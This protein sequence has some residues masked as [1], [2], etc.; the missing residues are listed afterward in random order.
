MLDG[1]KEWQDC[2]IES[3]GRQ[4]EF[5]HVVNLG[6]ES[7]EWAHNLT[8]KQARK[9]LGQECDL[10]IADVTQGFDANGFAAALGT[11]KGGG[12]LLI[13]DSGISDAFGTWFEKSLN[14]LHRLSE[15][16]FHPSEYMGEAQDITP[17]AEQTLAIEAVRKVLTGH[18]KRPLVVTADRGRGK[19]SALGIASAQ[20]LATEPK[21]ILVTAPNKTAV[22]TL[23]QRAAIELDIQAQGMKLQSDNGGCLEYIAPDALLRD[24]PDCDLLL[25]DEA[26]AIPLPMLHKIVERYHR[27]CLATT[28]HGYEGC[29]RGFSVKFEPWLDKHKKGW[30]ALR[31]TQPIRWNPTD[32][33]E[34]WLFDALLLDA[35]V[36]PINGVQANSVAYRRVSRDELIRDRSLLQQCFALLVNAHYQ[37][38]P[39]DLVQLLNDPKQVM[40]VAHANNQILAVVLA[41][42]EGGLDEGII[43]LVMQGKRRPAGHLVA[44]SLS[45]HLSIAEPSRLDS[46][47]VMRIA[48]HPQLQRQGI[49]SSTL[50]FVIQQTAQSYAFLSTSFG[51]TSELYRFW[52]KNSFRCLRLGSKQD[53]ASGCFSSILVRPLAAQM[54]WIEDARQLFSLQLVDTLRGQHKSLDNELLFSLLTDHTY[55]P[56]G[57]ERDTDALKQLLTRYVEGGNSFDS[58]RFAVARW[59]LRVLPSVNDIHFNWQWSLLL[60]LVLKQQPWDVVCN[61]FGFSGRKQAEQQYRVAVRYIL[62]LQ[63]K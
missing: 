27:V 28:V 10:V 34:A 58:S 16:E 21:K 45:N 5:N 49:G 1:T 63:C 39:N 4:G 54:T 43:E 24:T 29:G 56:L 60:D 9:L 22:E 57:F 32:P 25:V 23:F 35:E 33:L 40:F 30:K 26:S 38:S 44:V 8:F 42:E 50:N 19:S 14:R 53:S 36:E 13:R 7:I 31:L 46:L 6:V 37:T 17:F 2:L 18:R 55:Q 52:H 47:R 48:V 59:L 41:V 61:Q 11:L 15:T 3:F 51:A 20:I 62:D 12:L